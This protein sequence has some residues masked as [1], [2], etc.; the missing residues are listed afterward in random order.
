M[1]L[2]TNAPTL[3]N[4][5]KKSTL[6]KIALLIL[7]ACFAAGCKTIDGQVLMLPQSAAN[8]SAE[9]NTTAVQ[10]TASQT[11]AAANSVAEI[12][13]N[14]SNYIFPTPEATVQATTTVA[15]IATGGA[16]ANIRSAP[17]GDAE[18]IG[19]GP[20]NS[21]Y[22]VVSS[23]GDRQW[24]Q[25]CCVE[26]ASGASQ[27]GWVADSVIEIEGALDLSNA[28]PLLNTN[29][30]SQWD[31]AWSCESERCEINE[32]S[33]II[34]G[35]GR[36]LIDQQ[37]LDINHRVTWDEACFSTDDWSFEVD[38]F[39]GQNRSADSPDNF[40]YRYW[41]GQ[42]ENR[43]NSIVKLPDGRAVAAWCSGGER[44]EVAEAEGWKTVYIGKTCHDAR[45]GMLLTLS[46]QKQWLF[47]G[48]FSG[49]SYVDAF[50]GDVEIMEQ[51]LA[52]TNAPL[53]FVTER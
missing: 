28:T 2:C 29:M 34:D 16:R 37:W 19:K 39:T 50:F 21:T 4:R 48:Q 46:Y 27:Y 10:S 31:V 5:L 30:Q 12:D 51:T 25:I 43:Y 23:S 44:V 13:T 45:T 35:I 1:M 7:A 42:Q 32:C 26:D 47:T 9:Q 15:R 6:I 38:Q 36:G 33:A 40:L 8:S 24:W 49:N 22:T 53:L 11:S 41:I 3:P 14:V 18:I 17:N 20:A 52:Y